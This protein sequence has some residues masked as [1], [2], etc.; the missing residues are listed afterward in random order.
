MAPAGVLHR[1]S[2]KHPTFRRNMEQ[3][4]I[5][6]TQNSMSETQWV[7]KPADR[8]CMSWANA[9]VIGI[10][11]GNT[12]KVDS[13]LYHVLDMLWLFLDGDKGEECAD[14]LEDAQTSETCRAHGR[15]TYWHSFQIMSVN[16]E[17]IG[18][19]VVKYM[20]TLLGGSGADA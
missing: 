20:A 16:G 15:G 18:R 10:A 8:Q 7:V 12:V 17:I 14:D 3:N 9:R 19:G 4:E 1:C 13:I 5:Q 11:S 6:K 2:W